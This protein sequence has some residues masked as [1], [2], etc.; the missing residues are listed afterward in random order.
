MRQLRRARARYEI[1]TYQIG[2]WPRVRWSDVLEWI[3]GNRV[4]RTR[5]LPRAKAEE[6]GARAPEPEPA[7]QARPWVKTRDGVRRQRRE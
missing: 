3:E 4:Q 6:R 1:A 2:G 7:A 5:P